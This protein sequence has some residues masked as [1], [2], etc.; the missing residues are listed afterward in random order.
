LRQASERRD[1]WISFARLDPA[2]LSGVDAAAF[3]N[4][5]LSQFQALAS[6]LQIP[7]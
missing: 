7:P 1:F 3:R 4:L 6:S 5:L 2:D